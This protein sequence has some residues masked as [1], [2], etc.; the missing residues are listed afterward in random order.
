MY[1]AAHRVAAFFSRAIRS[2]VSVKRGSKEIDRR[3]ASQ[4]E[5][6]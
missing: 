3:D 4:S 6:A 1:K 2:C 5:A